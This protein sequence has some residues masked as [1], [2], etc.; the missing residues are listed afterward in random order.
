MS[1]SVTG[2]KKKSL[3]AVVLVLNNKNGRIY[4]ES[5]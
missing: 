4:I 3:N 5:K 2:K 1:P